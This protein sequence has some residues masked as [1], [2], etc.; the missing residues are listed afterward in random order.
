MSSS[1][2]RF[3]EKSNISE[4]MP[5]NNKI[6]NNILNEKPEKEE[7]NNKTNENKLPAII[8]VKQGSINAIEI[9]FENSLTEENKSLLFNKGCCYYCKEEIYYLKI[10][11]I[12]CCSINI[13]FIFPF[14]IILSKSGINYNTCKSIFDLL[15]I[16]NYLYFYCEYRN[17]QKNILIVY[18]ILNFLYLINEIIM[19]RNHKKNIFS[20]PNYYK[21]LIIISIFFF[22]I[23]FLF[24]FLLLYLYLYHLAV[25]SVYFS[26]SKEETYFKHFYS[27]IFLGLPPLILNSIIYNI[28]S[29]R[30][31]WYYLNFKFTEKVKVDIS[32][33]LNMFLNDKNTVNME[34]KSNKNLYLEETN[35]KKC[36]KFKKVLLKNIENNFIY[37]K[38]ENK[39]II[40]TLS[41]TDFQYPDLNEIFDKLSNFAST[42]S[43]TLVILFICLKININQ[44]NEYIT[45]RENIKKT[46]PYLNFKNIFIFYGNFENNLVKSGLS[47]YIITL[48]I[49]LFFILKRFY[50]GGFSKPLFI[51][52]SFILCIIFII[53]NGIYIFLYFLSMIFG[54]FSF[55]V[56]FAAHTP[57]EKQSGWNYCI[58]HLLVFFTILFGI[59]ISLFVKSMRFMES[60]REIK[61]DLQKLNN[62]ISLNENDIIK[63]IVY[64]GLDLKQHILEEYKIHNHPRNLYYKIKGDSVNNNSSVNKMLDNTNIQ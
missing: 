64:I 2:Q 16:F 63:E 32:K 23:Y 1:R 50:F 29:R 25:G 54:C 34:I 57:N 58:I 42:I 7:I 4:D 47:L 8:N 22:F 28:Y 18:L 45:L 33:N 3:H 49:I 6:N 14:L 31:L 12:V 30:K 43:V 15:N 19:I 36:Y 27:S 11:L 35:S 60:V 44:F 21:L 55:Y 40:N 39:S 13:I 24:Q 5:I 61:K 20:Q 10:H 26:Q 59:S 46:F 17:L 38:M 41:L 52:I 53:L 51:D 56:S 48:V 9:T 37:I 62:D